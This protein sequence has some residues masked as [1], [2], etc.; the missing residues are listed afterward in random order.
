MASFNLG[1]VVGLLRSMSAPFKQFIIWAKQIDSSDLDK[2]VLM[3]YDKI[4]SAWNQFNASKTF[5]L[6]PILDYNQNTPP[7]SPTLGDIYLLG[8]SP[9]GLWT[10]RAYNHAIWMGNVWD[11]IVPRQ[12]AMTRD[13]T[14]QD[15]IYYFNGTAWIKIVVTGLGTGTDGNLKQYQSGA[16]VNTIPIKDTSNVTSVDPDRRVLTDTIGTVM[17]DYFN[18]L[19]NRRSGFGSIDWAIGLHYDFD[20]HAALDTVNRLAIKSDGTTVAINWDMA[21]LSADWSVGGNLSVT[22]NLNIASSSHYIIG[23]ETI[24]G[25]WRRRIDTA[26]GDLIDE[27]RESGVWNEKNRIS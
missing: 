10:G 15:A 11:F 9:T 21:L 6:P 4:Y 19:L 2:V 1:N 23:S 17:I 16:W 7:S 5:Y 27:K 12:G 20:I 8:A 25:S 18:L 3:Y 14:N 24:D 22:S 13:S 26:T